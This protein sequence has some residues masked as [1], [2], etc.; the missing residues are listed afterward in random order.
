M[1]HGKNHTKHFTTR[2]FNPH[3][4]GQTD[5]TLTF[6][7][8]LRN[9]GNDRARNGR[10]TF[11]DACD[12]ARK[13]VAAEMLNSVPVSIVKD[14]CWAVPPSSRPSNWQARNIP[15]PENPEWQV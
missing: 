3:H 13:V 4:D 1:P 11:E 5:H 10:Y 9:A 6:S 7:D 8:T 12:I 2:K 14:G 15:E